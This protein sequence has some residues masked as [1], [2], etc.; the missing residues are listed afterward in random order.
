MRGKWTEDEDNLL[1]QFIG[2]FGKQW[3]VIASH[4]PNRSA[5][6]IAARWEKCINPALTKGPFTPDEDKA[7]ARFVEAQGTTSW[8]KIATVLPHRTAAQAY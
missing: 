2:R 4:I 7:I 5:T 1:R 3:S 6:Q 8:P